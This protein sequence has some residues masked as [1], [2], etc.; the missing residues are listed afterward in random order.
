MIA[1]NYSEFRTGLKKY[2]DTVEE[3]NETLII[4]RKSGKGT[5]MISLEEYN[6]MMETLHLLS[7]KKNADRLYE[8]IAQMKSGKIIE[9]KLE[10]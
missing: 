8:S 1:A 6:S 2:L 10:G 5:V 3:D 7:S 4:K 9:P